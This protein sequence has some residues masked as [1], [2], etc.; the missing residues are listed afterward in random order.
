MAERFWRAQ[1]NTKMLRRARALWASGDRRLDR[2]NQRAWARAIRRLGSRW[3]LA[4]HV[5]RKELV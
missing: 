1:M 5:P 2:H 3:L 4:T